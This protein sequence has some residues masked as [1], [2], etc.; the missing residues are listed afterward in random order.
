M[1]ACDRHRRVTT[2]PFQRPGLPESVGLTYA[3]CEETVWAVTPDGAA[4]G[5]AGGVN[6]ILAILLGA[7]LPLWL[8]AMPGMRQVQERAYRWVAANR[9]RFSGDRP[10]CE[11]FPE[12]CGKIEAQ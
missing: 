1:R 4:Y 3:R 12:E 7:P 10:Y 6:L 11:Q 5:Q 2:V 8:Y 9:H